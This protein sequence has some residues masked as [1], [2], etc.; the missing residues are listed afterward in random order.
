MDRCAFAFEA[1]AFTLQA[2]PHVLQGSLICNMLS[3]IK[4]VASRGVLFAQPRDL[5]L[6][7]LHTIKQPFTRLAVKASHWGRKKRGPC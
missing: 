4:Q 5:G 2:Y 7:V 1:K 6:A 3:I